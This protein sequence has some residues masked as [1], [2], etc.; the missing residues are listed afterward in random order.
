MRITE[1]SEYNSRLIYLPFLSCS[2]AQSSDIFDVLESITIIWAHG[3][4]V[5]NKTPTT[6]PPPIQSRHNSTDSR[7][8]GAQD[9]N[10]ESQGY[11]CVEKDGSPCLVCFI[12]TDGPI[13]C[14]FTKMLSRLLVLLTSLTCTALT[15]RVYEGRTVPG[16]SILLN[17]TLAHLDSI[18]FDA[19]LRNFVT[20]ESHSLGAFDV[21][22]SP[23]L[24]P[25]AIPVN[26]APG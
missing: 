15:L 21:I 2:V 14:I 9:S 23:E 17:V 8:I 13:E 18:G 12:N 4:A 11:I 5:E 16:S 25:T 24:V 6:S 1:M 19:E 10:S 26:V 7:T 22:D 3:M 20:L